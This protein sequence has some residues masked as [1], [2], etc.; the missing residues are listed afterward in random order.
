MNALPTPD[1]IDLAA[2][3]AVLGL[4]LV[5]HVIYPTRIVTM[6]AWLTNIAIFT[7]WIGYLLYRVVFD[8]SM[9][10]AAERDS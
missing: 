8:E 4:V 1:R 2:L 5:G 6:A 7:C 9:A 10:G 3:L